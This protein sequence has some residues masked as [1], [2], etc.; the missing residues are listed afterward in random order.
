M[1]L[2]PRTVPPWHSLNILGASHFIN[3]EANSVLFY[4]LSLIST[5]VV[6]D[7]VKYNN[8]DQDEEWEILNLTQVGLL[9]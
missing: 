6:F 5:V 2:C 8:E 9:T 3:S 1:S 4:W 7:T